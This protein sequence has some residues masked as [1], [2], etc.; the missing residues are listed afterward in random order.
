MAIF[1]LTGGPCAGKSTLLAE[2]SVRGYP[3]IREAA[4]EVIRAGARHPERD[5]LEFQRAVLRRQIELE[6]LECGGHPGPVFADRAV[7][8][9]F[10]Y[11]EY[12]RARKG[13]DLL[14]SDFAR[15]LERAWE[16]ATNRYHAVFLLEQSPEYITA[17]YRRE[18]QAEARAIHQ[19]IETCY[20][21]RHPRVIPV[22][23]C[24]LMERAETVLLLAE[25]LLQGAAPAGGPP[26]PPGKAFKN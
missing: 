22:P 2:L 5:P 18:S 8:D 23:W 20:R 3:V 6:R 7:G 19:A 26:A 1:V 16:D 11:L 15:E 21:A 12:Y 17:S 4:S 25:R 10:G 13:I 24:G 9:H 14:G